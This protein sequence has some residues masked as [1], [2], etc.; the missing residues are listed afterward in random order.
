M[1]LPFG[2]RLGNDGD[3]CGR[4]LGFVPQGVPF[5]DEGLLRKGDAQGT[6]SMG[7]VTLGIVFNGPGSR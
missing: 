7:K 6:G 2:S 4:V 3:E 1:G 5:Q